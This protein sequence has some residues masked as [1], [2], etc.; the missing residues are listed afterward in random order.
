[1]AE[2]RLLPLL[3]RLLA[4]QQLVHRGVPGG[5]D[6]DVTPEELEV[7]HRH[8]A[9]FRCDRVR[10]PFS[11][12]PDEPDAHE[13]IH[14]HITILMDKLIAAKWFLKDLEAVALE[15]VASQFTGRAGEKWTR[16]V[17]AARVT[18]TTSGIGHNSVVYR[19]LRDMVLAY[20]AVG[21]KANLHMRKLRDLV[22][23]HK[24]TVT[25]TASRVLAFFEAYD[26]AVELTRHLGV[27]LQVPAQDFATR[28][29]E[30]QGH[31]PEWANQLVVNHPERFTSEQACW[32]ALI[33]EAARKAA[34]KVMG[35]GGG[36]AQLGMCT[37]GDLDFDPYSPTGLCAPVGAYY[38]EEGYF[39][40]G[41]GVGLFAMR[42]PY[43]VVGIAGTRNIIA[44]TAPIRR[45][46]LSSPALPSTSGL[47][48]RRHRPHLRRA[49]P[50]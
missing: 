31:F 42:A 14:K 19:C 12:A 49:L 21:I 35:A 22:W 41:G 1:M 38:P 50:E 45:L 25:Q 15:G 3:Q 32:T 2:Q 47:S 20:P 5:L 30:M 8:A 46:R 26:R 44:R 16:V 37:V 13:A 28:F 10:S 7:L 24:D 9:R 36:V 48:C 6:R 43:M 34:G 33:E 27:T 39:Q 11:L 40:G 18:A 23:H 17:A 29:T 4:A